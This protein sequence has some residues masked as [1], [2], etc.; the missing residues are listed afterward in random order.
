[1][2]YTRIISELKREIEKLDEA[3]ETLESIALKYGESRRAATQGRTSM[4]REERSQVSARMK[5][6][7]SNKRAE[8]TT[9]SAKPEFVL[10]GHG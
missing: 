8:S 4:G 7:W 9:Q 3:I 10:S 1:V 6:Y 5:K 2:R